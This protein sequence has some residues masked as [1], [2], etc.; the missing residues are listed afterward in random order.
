MSDAHFAAWHS[1][2]KGSPKPSGDSPISSNTEASQVPG[3]FRPSMPHARNRRPVQIYLDIDPTVN[4]TF[5][6]NPGA[7]RRIVLN[8]F[9][10]SLKFTRTGF[11][12]VSLQQDLQT[13]GDTSYFEDR[14]GDQQPSVNVVLTV[15][16]SGKGISEEYLTHNLFTPF[17]QEDQ[18]AP[19]TGLGLSLVKQMV[20]SL[21]GSISVLSQVGQGTTMTVSLPISPSIQGS[22]PS[23]R[24]LPE[25]NDTGFDKI[26]HSHLAGRKIHLQ[27]FDET[28]HIRD[29]I[30][31]KED[32]K[33]KT[34]VQLL[35]SICHGWL[36]MVVVP[37][38][39]WQGNGAP[40]DGIP[41]EDFVLSLF[42]GPNH[43][44]G[45]DGH[46]NNIEHATCPCLVVCRDS[47]TM[48][49]LTKP[50]VGGKDNVGVAR[51]GTAY[52]AQP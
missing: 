11:I 12:R 18:F 51:S 13:N 39:E 7:F 20:V 5:Q 31:G 16:D 36:K 25:E 34:Q 42:K 6:T 14:S 15:S 40:K 22:R 52:I 1:T 17:S 37:P 46:T 4:W 33:Q 30:F 24:S 23:S 45:G 21:G 41:Q 48:Y 3:P 26:I 44:L 43:T 27:G 35:E 9:G 2:M 28:L 47:N 49:A 19:G 29:G 32:S 50:A 10:N 8:L 38:A